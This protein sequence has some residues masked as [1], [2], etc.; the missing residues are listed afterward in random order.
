MRF[1]LKFSFP[2]ESGNKFLSDPEFG[3]KLSQLVSDMKPEAV[4]LT[5]VSGRR[6]GYIVVNLDDASQI[7]A[8]GEPFFHWLNAEV[9]YIPV[10]TPEDL[11]R[12][13][14]EGTIR[15]WGRS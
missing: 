3:A 4:Y 6:G 8:Y 14:L 10:M 15:K 9:E 1:I 7:A 5:P 2:T 13:D 12:A 11:A